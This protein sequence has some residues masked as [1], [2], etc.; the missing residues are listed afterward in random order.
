MARELKTDTLDGYATQFAAWWKQ[1][2]W[3]GR[4]DRGRDFLI[5]EFYKFT[6][7]DEFE[8]LIEAVSSRLDGGDLATFSEAVVDLTKNLPRS[9]EVFHGLL[10]DKLAIDPDGNHIPGKVGTTIV[11]SRRVAN[12]K[13]KKGLV[14]PAIW[15]VYAGEEIER[16]AGSDAVDPLP[17][18]RTVFEGDDHLK[19]VTKAKA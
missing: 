15:P 1:G 13:T 17:D 10:A 16:Q 4:P 12:R 3:A 9:T 6:F 8:Y 18:H 5:Q 7:K 19:P 11:G 14:K 2:H